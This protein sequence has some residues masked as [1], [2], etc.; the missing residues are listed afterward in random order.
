M[1]VRTW[2][3]AVAMAMAFCASAQS[4]T[5]L[6]NSGRPA[7]RAW[8]AYLA[9]R[10][11]DPSL[12]EPLL[13]AL[14]DSER[15][16]DSPLDSEPWLAV[17]ALFDALIQSG[18]PVPAEAIL[19]FAQHWR[20]SVLLLL[21]RSGGSEETLLALREQKQTLAEWVAVN[22]LLFRMKSQNFFA[23]TL[24]EIEIAPIFEVRD[25][26]E[27]AG[28]CG[29]GFGSGVRQ[30]KLPEGF[31]PIALYQLEVDFIAPLQSASVAIEGPTNVYVRRVV[32]ETG[33]PIDWE[34][35]GLD[36]VPGIYRERYLAA[37]GS[38]TQEQMTQLLHPFIRI[39]WENAEQVS[40]EMA[41]NIDQQAT[42]IRDFVSGAA[43]AGLG[44]V[45]GM[46]LKI[47][48]EV[49]DIRRLT[50]QPLPKVE[51]REIVLE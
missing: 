7:D 49:R 8:G 16:R 30:R 37:L 33:K 9:A 31:P 48:P 42:A 19:P 22:N 24:Q 35:L 46:R 45:A 50:H 28:Y 29:G 25:T 6:L 43:T 47:Q 5:Q 10:S 12:G 32:M 36:K 26:S 14:Q 51:P 41:R 18:D 39:Y 13:A 1:V 11:H 27:D 2:L 44:S 34:D 15:W 17:Q 23:R 38:L 40:R 3:P 20:D 4:P 21:A